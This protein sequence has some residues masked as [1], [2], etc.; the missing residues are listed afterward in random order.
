MKFTSLYFT[1]DLK[2][3]SLNPALPIFKK[4]HDLFKHILLILLLNVKINSS[5]TN[6][7]FPCIFTKRSSVYLSVVVRQSKQ[8]EKIK[9]KCDT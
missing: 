2:N 1:E 5:Y 3:F 4:K 7:S 8:Q 9:E 6:S